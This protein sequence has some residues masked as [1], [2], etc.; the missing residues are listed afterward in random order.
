MATPANVY[1]YRS[2]CVRRAFVGLITACLFLAAGQARAEQATV[3]VAANF[4]GTMTK[5][6]SLFEQQT[7]HQVQASYGSTGKLYA[8]IRH[9]APYD[10]FLAADAERPRLL[11]EHSVAVAGSQFPYAEGRLVLWSRN[12]DLFRDGLQYLQGEP[13]RLA[14]GNPKT[15]P[16]GIAAIE[17]LENLGLAD[18]LKPKL[19]SGDSIAQ[20]FQFVATG[21]AHAGFVAQA[22][23]RAWKGNKDS[24]WLVPKTLHQPLSQHAIL[25]NRGANNAA[26]QAWLEFLKGA[27]AQAIIREDGYDTP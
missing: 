20:T 26:A 21:N 17:V 12:P 14:I 1:S 19:V 23:V 7:G 10:V 27:K 13:E 22:Q 9:G 3:A 24:A 18:S 25:L 4:T 11:A 2:T 15:A 16:Y 6:I 8:Q 5:L